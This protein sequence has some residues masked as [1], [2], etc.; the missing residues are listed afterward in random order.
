MGKLG[1][2]LRLHFFVLTDL[3]GHF[4]D[5]IRQVLDFVV[6]FG[7]DLRTVA[8]VGDPLCLLRDLLH[9]GHDGADEEGAGKQNDGQRSQQDPQAHQG[10]H[11]DLTVHGR[12]RG[13]E[14][15]YADDLAGAV[16]H[17]AADRHNPLAGIRVPA[18]KGLY[19]PGTDGLGNLRRPGRGGIPAAIGGGHNLPP[20]VDK[21][22]LQTGPLLHGLGV[23]R[24]GFVKGFVILLPVVLKELRG[25]FC[26]VVQIGAHVVVAVKG[27]GGGNG[28]HTH[29]THGDDDQGD[30]CQPPLVQRADFLN[31]KLHPDY[32]PHL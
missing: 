6:V 17:G 29:K 9:R 28:R 3:D 31:L 22:A 18:H 12:G 1:D 11:K 32:A 13:N 16:D 24:T 8:A 19:G 14:P 26:P 4:I 7:F 25:A 21:L 20:L 10:H 5:G 15:Q 2:E 30:V 27:I 23:G